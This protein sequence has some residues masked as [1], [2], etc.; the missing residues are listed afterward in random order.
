MLQNTQKQKPNTLM[1]EQQLHSNYVDADMNPSN[2]TP[3]QNL[4]NNQ[5]QKHQTFKMDPR[6]L[7]HPQTDLKNIDPNNNVRNS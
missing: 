7:T 1:N 6:K 3:Q 5:Y 2:T 4:F